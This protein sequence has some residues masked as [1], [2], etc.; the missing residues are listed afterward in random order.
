M[1]D[2]TPALKRTQARLAQNVQT[3]LSDAQE[4]MRLAAGEAG[5]GFKEARE[6]LEVSTQA[7]RKQLAA[8]QES[9]VQNAREASRATDSY[10]RENPWEAVGIGAA[11]GVLVGLLLA[12]RSE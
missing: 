5:Q 7:A 12:S 4:L 8:M 6:R 11:L 9:A 10:V 3:V 2:D 1:N